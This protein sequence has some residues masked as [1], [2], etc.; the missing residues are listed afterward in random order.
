MVESMR[1]SRIGSR[2]GSM[3]GSREGSRGESRVGSMRESRIGSRGESRIGSMVGSMRASRVESRLGSRVGSMGES[4]GDRGWVDERAEGSLGCCQG[5]CG[6]RVSVFEAVLAITDQATDE[7]A[8]ERGLFK[9]PE[10]VFLCEGIHVPAGFEL[11]HEF[12]ERPAGNIEE[13]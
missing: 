10:G 8:D 12:M 13:P 11:S 4:I 9:E 3:V 6:L 5:W 7:A 2:E 1:A